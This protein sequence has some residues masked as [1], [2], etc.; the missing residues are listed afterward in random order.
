MTIACVTQATTRVTYTSIL[1]CLLFLLLTYLLTGPALHQ[2]KLHL[3][4]KTR[5]HQAKPQP[6]IGKTDQRLA[7]P[8]D[9]LAL[10]ASELS[11]L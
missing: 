1:L 8:S 3:F 9:L 11:A 4:T 6:D 2:F 5:R 7:F 10:S